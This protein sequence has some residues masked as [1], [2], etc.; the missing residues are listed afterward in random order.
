MKKRKIDAK[1]QGRVEF[2]EKSASIQEA[3]RNN[4]GAYKKPG[5]RN[6]HKH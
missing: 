5:S 6:Y 2:F 3:N 1:L 4:S